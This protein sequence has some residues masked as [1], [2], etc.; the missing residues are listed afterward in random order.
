VAE[1]TLALVC[2]RGGS[3]GLLNKNLQTIRG[4]TLLAIAIRH[5]L[6]CDGITSVLV[7]TDSEEIAGEARRCGAT[8]SFMRPLEL[9]QDETD[10]WLV[11]RDA[12]ERVGAQSDWR[13]EVLVV[14]P[15]TA[16]LREPADIEKCI[17]RFA[18]GD[19]DGVI[20]VSQARRNPSFNM[21]SLNNSDMATLLVSPDV[22][23][24]NRQEAPPV[25]DMTTVAYV[26]NS[27]FVLAKDSM[28]KGRLAGVVIP[29]RRAWDID[30]YLDLEICRY[31]TTN[32]S[33][34]PGIG[35]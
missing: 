31:L 24:S 5:A 28:W 8:V 34:R 2:A 1:K 35:P 18:Q 17:N 30:D 15:P 14:I 21:V 29:Q 6:H 4:E 33:T 9:A 3:K 25:F 22:P 12:L 13:P 32:D 26:F 11:W 23:I 27:S 7:S 16:P 20:T 10:Q 19:V